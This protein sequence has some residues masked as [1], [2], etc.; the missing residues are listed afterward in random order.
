MTVSSDADRL[1]LSAFLRPADHI[2]WGQACGEPTTL[3][4]ALIRAGGKC[5]SPLGVRRH[6]LFRNPHGKRGRKA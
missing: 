6:Q 1:N 4:E 2:V 5:R 3:V